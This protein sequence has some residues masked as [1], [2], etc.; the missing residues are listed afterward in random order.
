M[1]SERGRYVTRKMVPITGGASSF[2]D[3]FVVCMYI[4]RKEEEYGE[5]TTTTDLSIYPRL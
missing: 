2:L 3:F 5:T 4:N 1:Y